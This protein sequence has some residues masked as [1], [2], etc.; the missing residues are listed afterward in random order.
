MIINNL[1]NQTLMRKY[2]KNFKLNPSKHELILKHIEKIEEGQ[3]EA[4]TKNYI[5]F[6]EVWLKGILGYD[7]DENI[8][9][10]EKEEEGR[11]KSEFI[12]KS[13]DKKFMVVELKDQ[14]TDLDKPQNRVNDKRTP[15]D[16]AFDYA[17]HTGDI[18]WILV[19]NYNEFRLYNWHKKGHYIS[20]NAAELLDKTIFSYF[21]LSFSKKSYIETGFIDKLMD[22]TI[23]V[24][25]ELEKEFYKLYNETRLMLIKEFEEIN[26]LSR[27]DAI[28][29]AQ[30]IMN[31]YMFICFAEDIE[32]L[33]P[34]ISTDTIQT[35][36]LKG[37]LRHGSIWQR[38]NEL[39]LD[40]NE[41]NEYKKISQYNGGIFKEDLDHIKIRDI[42]EDQKF[43]ND[44]YQNWKF[45]EYEKEANIDLGPYGPKV[46]PIY[47]NML[48][49]STFDFST[50]L[51]VNILGH[52]F[53]NSIGDIEELK[54]DSKGR[55]K[56]EGI[57]Y[58]PD[59]ITDY[60]C[61]N[62][63]IPY[64]S[65]NGKSETVAELIQEYS[66]GQEIE[67]LESEVMNIKIVDPACGSGAFLNKASD[68]L[69][70]IHKSIYA[71]KKGKYTTTIKTKGGKGKD[72]V[73]STAKHIKLDSFFDEISARREILI[74]N[75]YGVDL[76]EESVDITKLALFLKVCQ[77]DRKLP[78]LENNIKCGNSLIDDPEFNDKPFRWEDEF[79]A[80][81]DE[82]GFDVVVGNPPYVRQEKIKEIKP[83]LKENYEIFDGVADL[84]VY[85]FEKGMKILKNG[86]YFSFISS[87]MF[88]R[89]KYGFKL[90]KF[91]LNNKLMKY[92]DYTSG[93]IFE[94]AKV[95][96]C[97]IVLKKEIPNDNS[98]ICVNEEFEINQNRF[99]YEDWV[100]ETPEILSLID[101]INSK[102]IK[103]KEIKDLNIYRGILTGL[104]IAFNI[105]KLMKEKLISNDK[106]SNRLIKPLIRG[107]DIKKWKTDFKD[108]YLIFTKRGI[109][110]N[111]YPAIKSHLSHYK[112][113]L[114][115]KNSGQR[116]GR[117]AGN[118]EWYEIQDTVD[119]HKELDKEKLIFPGISTNLFATYDDQ[120]IYPNNSAYI[121]TS[122]K[123]DLKYL[124]AIISS[125]T[126]NFVFKHSGVPLART[127]SNPLE[128]PR[129]HLYKNYIEKL[130]IIVNF[131]NKQITKKADQMLKLNKDLMN[132]INS[133]KD[134]LKH[135][136]NIE[137]FSQ[138]LDK[139]Y[140]LTFDDFLTELKK[141]KVD[142]T[143]RKNYNLL[144]KEFEE[145]ISKINPLLQEIEITDKEIDQMVYELY[146]L[147]E[148]EIKIIEESLS[149]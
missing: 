134:W 99:N 50:E 94:E 36:I 69:L 40:I 8:L 72:K 58:T 59:Y 140:K 85:F 111:E 27:L 56:K 122:D 136:F 10:D 109:E 108:L 129:Y 49:I 113:Q 128:R 39:F 126:L 148:D 20:F 125:K 92:F 38:L 75:I 52:I 115:P 104:N 5:Y 19:S 98:K 67:T 114:I 86:G 1:F 106:S 15:V 123:I 32:L 4:E 45:E 147:T 60:I 14:K 93:S 110:I 21:M 11:G 47:R 116:I 17:Q 88:I 132:E 31:R 139:Y 101:K 130:P 54:E 100:F 63:I 28:H 84:Y 119:Y 102:G 42:V 64:L 81:F 138:K 13:D 51:D 12:L 35:P 131:E 57:F 33:P 105:D 9:I 55:R 2:S 7:L 96:P 120:R 65:K 24:E 137:K 30:M 23:V 90:R 16:Q 89:A 95:D 77:E 149:K 74:H 107:Q 6:Y 144:K 103:F 118:Y 44:V 76:N 71:F 37:N 133:F 146:G 46:N 141:K 61:R 73:K 117:K 66:T 53:E 22:K 18:D 26:E 78:D 145:S 121:I 79:K 112:K 83:Y 25:R 48:T 3:F 62:T 97:I 124:S 43:F 135:T 127:T 70:E 87:N 80:I 68:I 29:Y 41:G 143:S 82:G 91:I 34:Q 142:I